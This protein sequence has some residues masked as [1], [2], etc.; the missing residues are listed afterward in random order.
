MA[1]PG[2]RRSSFRRA[3][4][5]LG[6][7]ASAGLLVAG[8]GSSSKSSAAGSTATAPAAEA[9]QFESAGVLEPVRQAPPLELKN[10]LGQPVNIDNYRGK[11][12]LVTFV[13]THCPDVCPLM[14]GNLHNAQALLG[15]EAS[16]AQ[17]IAVSVDPKGD[18]PKTVAHFLALHEQTG[19]MQY[20]I[21]DTKELAAVWKAW[22]V[23]AE[24]DAGNPDLVEH[25]GL[26][27]GITG[28]GKRL[29]IYAANFKP[30]EIAHDVPLLA[31]Q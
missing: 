15:T 13:Y 29:T 16:K 26:V 21:G 14:V 6:A 11:A 9:S 17:I 28:S 25:S 7:L 1:S 8:C 20:L 31:A 27:Y 23:G 3:G 2:P 19:K 5:L 24:R 10:Y 4:A 12:V 22:G 18:T 30:S